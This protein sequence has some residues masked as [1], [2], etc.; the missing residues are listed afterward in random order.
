MDSIIYLIYLILFILLVILIIKGFKSLKYLIQNRKC[1]KYALFPKFPVKLKECLKLLI[2][3]IL[4]LLNL[5][6]ICLISLFIYGISNSQGCA[7]EYRMQY[8]K[9][10]SALNQVLVLEYALEGKQVKDFQNAN[11]FANMIISRMQ[12]ED[13]YVYNIKSD[14]YKFKTFTEDEIKKYN[15]TEYK[16]KPFFIDKSGIA[17]I[18]SKF[19]QGCNNVD[20]ENHENSSC[21]IDVDVNG[22]REP[23][24]YY[25]PEKHRNVDRITLVVD[26]VS[27]ND[28][29]IPPNK[30]KD[31]IYDRR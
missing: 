29:I 11:E 8:K 13:D 12:V 21:L 7:V 5:F 10:L 16:D 9:A 28:K 26:G 27:V 1:F 22:F 6:I 31:L 25:N 14:K 24:E 3:V 18:V 20:L 30:Y 23:N 4:F 2:I 17:Y 19:E 15:L